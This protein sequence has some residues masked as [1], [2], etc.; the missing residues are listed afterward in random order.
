MLICKDWFYQLRQGVQRFTAVCCAE[1]WMS[2]TLVV[3]S[4]GYFVPGTCFQNLIADCD[5]CIIFRAWSSWSSI[6]IVSVSVTMVLGIGQ[7]SL[8]TS[9]VNGVTRKAKQDLNFCKSSNL[10]RKSLSRPCNLPLHSST[11]W[12]STLISGNVF[13]LFLRWGKVVEVSWHYVSLQKL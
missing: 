2:R 3:F 4:W 8:I 10:A 1:N 11:L 9:I 12:S 5:L 7:P 6:A 13:T